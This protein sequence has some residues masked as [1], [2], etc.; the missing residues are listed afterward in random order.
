MQS[1]SVVFA[2]TPDFAAEHLRAL[3]ASPHRVVGVYTQPDRPAG[4]GK[5]LLPGPVKALAEEHG[6]AVFQPLNLK[7][8]AD[9]QRLAELK[10]DLMVVVAYGLILP[11]AVLAIPRLGCINVHAS[12]LPRW[13][14]AAPI[15]RAIA[16]GDG[17]SGITIMEMEAGLD[18]GPMLATAVCPIADDETG[19]SLHDTLAQ[20]GPE[21]LLETIERLAQGAV[22]AQAQDDTQATYAPKLSKAEAA[23]DW[24]S[25]AAEIDRKVRAFNP[26]PVAYGE[27]GGER[28]RIWSGASADI[29]PDD[30]APETKSE[31]RSDSDAA[32]GR[33]LSASGEGILVACA[34]GVYRIEELQLPGRKR[35]PVREVLNSRTA[36]FAPGQQ[37]D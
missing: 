4:R 21:L 27:L 35:L 10:P 20:L 36:L 34:Q 37:F 32:P 14:G 5:K 9:Q 25:S 33:I 19:G 11:P 31:T 7:D 12:L 13:R 30:A 23:I 8:P 26:F 2:G 18:T 24:T 6:L 3:L 29:V 28:I 22:V 15:Q 16:A 1:L 17:S